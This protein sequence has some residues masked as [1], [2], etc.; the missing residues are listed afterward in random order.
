MC[1]CVYY[2]AIL[3]RSVLPKASLEN[4]QIRRLPLRLPPDPALGSSTAAASSP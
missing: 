3:A 4:K 1:V 2:C